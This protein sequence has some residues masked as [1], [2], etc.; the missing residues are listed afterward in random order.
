[1]EN[2]ELNNQNMNL[3]TTILFLSLFTVTNL[4]AQIKEKPATLETK[5]GDIEGTLLYPISSKKIP[6]AL[7]IAVSSPTDMNGNNPMMKNNSLKM[8]AESLADNGIASLRYDKRGIAESKNAMSSEKNLRFKNYIK[9]AKGWVS[10]LNQDSRFSEIII[11][12]HSEGS[13]IGMIASQEKTVSKFISIAGPGFPAGDILEK[14]L[15]A[16][17]PIM[18]A[19]ASPIIEK[20]ENGKTVDSIPQMLY[21]IFRP[22][23][24]PYLISWFKYDPSQEISKLKKPV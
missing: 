3:K 13:L 9:D 14:Q 22:S 4:F 21:T 5:T 23:L 20:L 15:K 6:L 16:Q 2:A 12:G 24:Q 19:Q 1:N 18:S 11:I 17:A 8:L 10:F 7:I